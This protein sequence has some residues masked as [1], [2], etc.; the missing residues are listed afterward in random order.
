MVIAVCKD[1]IVCVGGDVVV[2]DKKEVC[3]RGCVYSILANICDCVV[4]YSVV[5]IADVYPVDPAARAVP[6][7]VEGYVAVLGAACKV[8]A[9]V[10]V[11][12][13]GVA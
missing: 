4:E 8:D 10:G 1:S 7:F 11:A 9:V 13:D 12:G 2:E 5:V 6:D 3:A